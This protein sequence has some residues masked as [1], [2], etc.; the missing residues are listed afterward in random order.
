MGKEDNEGLQGL[1]EMR[2]TSIRKIFGFQLSR[3]FGQIVECTNQFLY[4]L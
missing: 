1:K 3:Y 4:I 2:Y